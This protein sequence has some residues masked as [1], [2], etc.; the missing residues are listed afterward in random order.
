MIHYSFNSQSFNTLAR[1]LGWGLIWLPAL[2]ASTA[3][4][5]VGLHWAMYAL[6]ASTLYRE[7]WM[8]PVLLLLASF[9]SGASNRFLIERENRANGL[10]WFALSLFTLIACAWL[11]D[12]DLNRGGLLYLKFLPVFP[13]RDLHPFVLMM[14]ATGLIGMLA[15][16][17]LGSS[18]QIR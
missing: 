10:G 14:P 16:G 11:T 13:H 17:Y 6:T 8:H 4:W 2:S 9:L 15:Y 1:R 3:L 18:D 5:L 7:P 12:Y